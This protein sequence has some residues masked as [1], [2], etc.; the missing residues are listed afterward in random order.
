M[1]LS[2]KQKSN[3]VKD[4]LVNYELIYRSIDNLKIFSGDNVDYIKSKIKDLALMS[5]LNYSA[6]IPQ[7]LPN[8]QFEM[9]ENLPANFNLIIQKVDKGN[10]VVIVEKV[11]YIRNIEKIL[12]NAAK[13]EKMKIKKGMLNFSINRKRCINNYLRSS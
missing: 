1:F 3:L 7:H 11:V 8:E 4:Y 10:S 13:F 6:N 9:L 5:F 2:C 12:N